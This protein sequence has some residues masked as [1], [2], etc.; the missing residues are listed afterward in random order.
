MKLVLIGGIGRLAPHYEREVKKQGHV[1]RIFNSI[2]PGLAEKIGSSDALLL[3]TGKMS[4]SIRLQ[5][6]QAARQRS[7]PFFQFQSCGVCALREC[8]KNIDGGLCT[9]R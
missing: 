4:H 5:A 1:L 9:K 7:I 2:E 3:C 6:L 8:I